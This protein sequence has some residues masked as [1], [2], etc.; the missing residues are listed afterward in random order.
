MRKNQ[1]DIRDDEG[2]YDIVENLDEDA[3][4]D[5]YAKEE[6]YGEDYMPPQ[7]GW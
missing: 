1:D 4:E 2:F 7:K 3:K 5:E 6:E